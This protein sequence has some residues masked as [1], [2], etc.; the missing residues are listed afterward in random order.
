[1]STESFRILP[2]V[3]NVQQSLR[4]VV[5]TFSADG[6]D[7]WQGE[8]WQDLNKAQ[9]SGTAEW[10]LREGSKGEVCAAGD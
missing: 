6:E 10:L 1:M 4:T 3:F 9:R 7:H 2:G 8:A 5:E